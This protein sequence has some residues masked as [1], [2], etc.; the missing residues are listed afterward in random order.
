MLNQVL[1]LRITRNVSTQQVGL[2]TLVY[3][4][5]RHRA[6]CMN[7]TSSAVWRECNGARTTGQIAERTSV[8]LSTPVSEEMVQLAVRGARCCRRSAPARC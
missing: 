8:E 4:E 2:E 3:D 5:R 1:P 6:F 7:A